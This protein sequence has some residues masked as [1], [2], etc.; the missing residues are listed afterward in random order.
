M[1]ITPSLWM[2]SMVMEVYQTLPQGEEGQRPDHLVVDIAREAAGRAWGE[3]TAPKGT[4]E[5][6][7][8]QA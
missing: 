6:G 2:R 1:R 5:E 7:E 3:K 4:G 8:T